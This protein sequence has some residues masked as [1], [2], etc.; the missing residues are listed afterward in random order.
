MRKVDKVSIKHYITHYK[1][2]GVDFIIDKKRRDIALYKGAECTFSYKHRLAHKNTG[3]IPGREVQQLIARVTRGVNTYIKKN[4]FFIPEVENR[5]SS[6]FTNHEAWNKLPIDYPFL[7]V[8]VNHCFWRIAFLSGYIGKKLYYDVLDHENNE[9]KLL[10]NKALACIK[11]P[12]MR[13]Y[14]SNGKLLYEITEDKSLHERIYNNI[15]YKAYNLMGDLK[16]SLQDNC[17]AYRTD[18]IMIVKEY[19]PAVQDYMDS[20]N[21]DVSVRNCFKADNRFYLDARTN[22]IRHI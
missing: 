10:R 2:K 13:E 19:L 8:D 22:K 18:G 15:R 11:A 16:D 21:F 12:R 14:F 6:T 7:Y 4:Q 9:Y 1:N 3:S 5:H 17:L 20:L